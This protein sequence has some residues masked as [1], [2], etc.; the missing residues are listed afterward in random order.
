[1]GEEHRALP[2]GFG[3]GTG[4]TSS[5]DV[6]R[7]IGR[8]VENYTVMI[9][10]S[11]L[12][13]WLSTLAGVT[14]GYVYYPWAYP[15]PSAIFAFGGLTVF[16]AI[17]YLFCMKVSEEG[18]KKNSNRLIAATMGSVAILTPCIAIFDPIG[19]LLLN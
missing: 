19:S 7:M 13:A 9:T 15:Q 5:I 8:R 4:G 10:I 1:M 18:S 14:A 17:G 6:E 12:A 11:F 16:E 3:S 2:K